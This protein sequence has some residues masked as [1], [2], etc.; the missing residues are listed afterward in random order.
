MPHSWEYQ[1]W[2]DWLDWIVKR[3]GKVRS[4]ENLI[5]IAT[6]EHGEISG[7]SIEEACRVGM[8]K[9]PKPEDR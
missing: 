8:R 9:V 2:L 5:F 4:C 7:N 3:G 6:A 1:E